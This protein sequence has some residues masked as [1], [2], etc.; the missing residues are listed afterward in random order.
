MPRGEGEIH[1]SLGEARNC[2]P[3]TAINIVHKYIEYKIFFSFVLTERSFINYT[4][5][6]VST[7]ESIST[8]LLL[9]FTNKEGKGIR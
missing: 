8:T 4:E 2:Q 1:S 3:G 6:I 7:E 5:N 9:T